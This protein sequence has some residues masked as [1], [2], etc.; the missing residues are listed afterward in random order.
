MP[1]GPLIIHS[2]KT[3][4]L[5]VDAP[6]AGEARQA[7]SPFA[8]LER[9]PEHIHTYRITQLWLWNARAAGHSADEMLESGVVIYLQGLGLIGT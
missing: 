8:E 1:D 6:T 4:L 9:S 5:E 3:V 2:D 7:L